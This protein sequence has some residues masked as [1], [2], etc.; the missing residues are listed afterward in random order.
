MALTNRELAENSTFV[1]AL[2]LLEC[3]N[4]GYVSNN[5]DLAGPRI[6]CSK[7]RAQ[8][9]RRN[10]PSGSCLQFLRM[11][12]Y[13]YT[14]AA[15][16][17]ESLQD[18]LVKKLQKATEQTYTSQTAINVAIEIQSF[19]TKH[20]SGEI[21]FEQML[22]IVK[23]R[24]GIASDAEAEKAFYELLLYSD[25]FE[26]HKALTI[27]TCTM[28][29]ELFNQLL[30]CIHVFQGIDL[31]TAGKKI[32]KLNR[33]DKRCEDFEK[34]VGVSFESAMTGFSVSDFYSN[35]EEARKIR[36]KFI[37]GKPFAISA[38][39][40]EKAFNLAKDS[41]SAFAYLHNA[42]ATKKV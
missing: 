19:Y 18:E 2:S 26:E 9:M 20:G 24:L 15:D 25:S 28:L 8:T 34:V 12:A 36:N 13:F 32:S 31:A 41:F 11:I 23:Q 38:A 29:E 35:W 27:L 37:H 3:S 33:F 17:V 21:E 5:L 1:T 14:K 6:P 42:F 22:K 30:I 39:I 4:C 16:R 40:A 7:C 10:F